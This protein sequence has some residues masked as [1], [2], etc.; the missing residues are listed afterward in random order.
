MT[1][2]P[3]IRALAVAAVLASVLVPRPLAADDL[4]HELERVARR[5]D[6]VAAMIDEITASRSALA[7]Q[8]KDAATR[9]DGLEAELAA[10]GAALGRVTARVEVQRGLARD[11]A[12][13]LR[14]AF[15]D[16]TETR[17]A[18]AVVR[19]FAIESARSAYISGPGHPATLPMMTEDVTAVAVGLEYLARAGRAHQHSLATYEVLENH[20]ASQ[21]E[22]IAAEDEALQAQLHTLELLEADLETVHVSYQTQRVE[23]LAALEIQ[24]HLLETLD[25]EIA[26]FEAELDGLQADQGSLRRRIAREQAT[27]STAA[28]AVGATGFVRPVPGAITSGFGP[29]HHPILGYSRPH[30]GVDFRAP[31]GQPIKAAQSGVVILANVWGGYGRAVVID[32]GGGLATLYAHQSSLAVSYGDRVMAGDVIGKVGTSGL[33]AGP[34]LHFEVR[35]GGEPVDPAPYLS[36]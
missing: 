18:I 32:H 35:I 2:R 33:S 9:L 17:A 27:A 29:R 24:A 11:T 28:S 20:A 25:E 14:D 30:T 21:A 36:G 12:T 13:R 26:H 15:E 16:L 3:G 4:D 7:A 8:I 19:I 31:H 23:M 34:H 1:G 5:I 6:E 22:S 10:A